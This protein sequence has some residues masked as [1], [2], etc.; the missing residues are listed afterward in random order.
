MP[1][2]LRRDKGWI[3][4]LVE[5]A[6]GATGG[7][8]ELCDFPHLGVEL[9]TIPV[10]GGGRPRES[11]W[12]C[13]APLDGSLAR[14]WDRSRVC[15][16]LARVLWVPIRGEGPPGERVV[17]RPRLWRPTAAQEA[18]LRADW[19]ALAELIE[20]GEWWQLTARHGQVLQV[21][22][23]AASSREL[24]WVL[25]EDASWVR[26]NPRGFYLRRSFTAEVLATRG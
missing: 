2:D 9:K 11:T 14:S 16:K 24:V 13:V 3:G 12:V 25:D 6:L 26:T 19:E 18:R 21:R 20:L 8:R 22:P 23:K 4:Q 17:D 1:V 5:R 15:R 7:P 10:D